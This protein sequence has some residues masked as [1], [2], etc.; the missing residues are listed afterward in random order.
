MKIEK[1]EKLIESELDTIEKDVGTKKKAKAK[2]S[3]RR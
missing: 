1:E 3:K 2:S